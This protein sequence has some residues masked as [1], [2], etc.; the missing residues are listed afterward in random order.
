MAVNDDLAEI[1]RAVQKL[2]SDPQRVF[3][4]LALQRNARAHARVAQ[5]I[6]AYLERPSGQAGPS[7]REYRQ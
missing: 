4:A 7:G 2:V 1:G 3:D 6:F 5:E